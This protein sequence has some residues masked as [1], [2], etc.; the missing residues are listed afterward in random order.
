VERI[1]RLKLGDMYEDMLAKALTACHSS[2]EVYKTEAIEQVFGTMGKLQP[3]TLAS[4]AQTMRANL[5]GIWRSAGEQEKKKTKR[6]QKDIE[7]EVRR[8]YDV[9]LDTVESGLA[10]FPG[11]YALLCAKAALLHDQL[12]YE[13]D[14][15]RASEFSKRRRE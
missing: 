10:K 5:A 6:K 1:G 13:Q 9:A 11:H 12:T 3:K 2:A 8:G 4:L 14:I 7:A 15:S